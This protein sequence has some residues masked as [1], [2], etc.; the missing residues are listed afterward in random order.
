ML[1][2]IAGCTADVRAAADGNDSAATLEQLARQD[3]MPE[4]GYSN[5]VISVSLPDPTVIRAADGSFYL[6][7]TEN[8]RNLPIYKSDDL[9][10]WSYVGT[11]FSD[12]TRPQ[13]VPEGNLWAPD[14]NIIDGRY[15]LY[16]SKSEWGGEWTCGIG[17]ATAER[18]EGPFTD[19]GKLFISSEIG[20][21]NSIDPFY[22]EEGDGRK[23][24]F[25]GSFHG[26]YGIELSADGLSVKNGAEKRMI[27]G[28][29]TEGTYII[30]HDG[31]YYLIGS[32]GT[33]CAGANSSYRMV[34]A[35]SENLFGPYVNRAGEPALDNGFSELLIRSDKVVGPGHCSEFVRDD[36]GQYWVFYHGYTTDDIDGGRKVFLD[37]VCWDKDGWPVMDGMRPSE[38]GMRPFIR[39]KE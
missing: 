20:V 32:A 4:G 30:R 28:T 23:Y 5:P 3:R 6:Y 26:I 1:I 18:P 16:Y 37:R 36:N 12:A 38:G 7:A 11:A 35:R 19:A 10:S 17:V 22:I 15:V 14:I 13:M 29:L 24:L 2:V 31:Y 33:C 27:A 21:R 39:K 25:W 34:V 8:I 9:V